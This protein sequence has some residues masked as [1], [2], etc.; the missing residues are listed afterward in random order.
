MIVQNQSSTSRTYIESDI[1]D[2][3]SLFLFHMLDIPIPLEVDDKY[4]VS[5]FP[6]TPV[7][8]SRQN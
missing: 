2:N 6:H 5:M 4:T 3:K 1:C 8:I 7:E